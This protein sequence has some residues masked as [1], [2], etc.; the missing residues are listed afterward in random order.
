MLLCHDG[1][2][3][4]SYNPNLIP[5][6]SKVDEDD[7]CM[8]VINL[9]KKDVPLGVTIRINER[10]GAVMVARV[11]HGESANRCSKFYLILIIIYY[12][13]NFKKMK[14]MVSYTFIID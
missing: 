9:V 2:A 10:N 12:K 3:N 5:V 4:K 7:V 13:L 11:M 14:T 1:V 6:C 8:K